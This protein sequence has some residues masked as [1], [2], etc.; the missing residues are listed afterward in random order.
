MANE[1]INLD[2]AAGIA[3]YKNNEEKTRYDKILALSEITKIRDIMKK[4]EIGIEEVSEIMNIATAVETKLT[5]INQHER[6]ILGKYLIWIGEYSKRFSKALRAN[7]YYA[8]YWTKLTPRTQELRKE[9][10]KDYTEQFKQ[11]MHAYFFLLHSPLSING[12]L[13][14]SLTMDKKEIQYNQ[15]PVMPT[16]QAAQQWLG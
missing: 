3:M 11:N 8:A 2:S 14:D 4:E 16:Q 15:L 9:I 7:Q 12:A 6:Y 10:I 13:V 1:E 5:N